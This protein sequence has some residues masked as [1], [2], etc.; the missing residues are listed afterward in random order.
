VTD[1]P[2]APA[3]APTAASRVPVEAAPA[4]AATARAAH[5]A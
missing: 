2:P 5:P 3:T 1:A 4:A